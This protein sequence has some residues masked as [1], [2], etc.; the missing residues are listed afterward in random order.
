MKKIASVFIVMLS[1]YAGVAQV[2]DAEETLK[3]HSADTVNG[4]KKGGTVTVNVTQVSL[5]NWSA[6]GQSQFAGNALLS[7]FANYTKG[8]GLWE[9][10]FDIG[11]GTFKQGKDGEWWKSDDKIDF[12]SKYGQNLYKSWYLA[13][14][15]NFKTQMDQGYNYPDDSTIISKFMAPG[16]LL[17]ALG[18][19]Y[20][21]N[22]NFTAYIA[23]LT[24]KMTFVTD[25]IL[26]NA[27]SFGVD[28]AEYD[29]NGNMVSSGKKFRNEFGGYLRFFYK[30][31][32]MENVDLQ[33]KLDLFSNYLKD[34]QNIDVNWEVLITM[35]VNKYISATIS[36]QLIYDDDVDIAFEQG[37]GSIIYHPAAQFKEVLAVGFSYKF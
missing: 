15:I 6:G 7:V 17:A 19:D 37:D 16:Y 1:F 12:T 10:Y 4:W 35:K 27:G 13:G 34:P 23:P 29:D 32:L 18:F 8:N 9:N 28:A 36:T 25:T 3:K 21:P 22:A 2:T 31:S 24:S 5:T 20:K 33:T 11:Y 26:A 14:L 30:A